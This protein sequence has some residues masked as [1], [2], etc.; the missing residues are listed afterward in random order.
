MN[1]IATDDKGNQRDRIIA[2]LLENANAK[3][4][5][6]D[7][8]IAGIARITGIDLHDVAKH[9]W[10][11][12]KQGLVGF[13]TKHVHGRTVP[14]RFRLTSRSLR[15]GVSE[16][17]EWPSE[18]AD[19]QP[20]IQGPVTTVAAVVP[21]PQDVLDD[22]AVMDARPPGFTREAFPE[23][24]TLIEREEKR[25]VIE[26]AARALEQAGLDDL[27]V[28]ALDAVPPMSALEAEVRTLIRLFWRPEWEQPGASLRETI[29]GLRGDTTFDA[30]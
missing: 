2:V 20:G 14:Y 9:L 18:A 1:R 13:S 29:T 16:R 12:Q 25:D 21:V 22:A 27:A 11:L 7:M 17:T 6:R 19:S 24:F 8:D 23:I 15:D 30:D 3:G 28:Q 5:V 26:Q 10:G 4:Y